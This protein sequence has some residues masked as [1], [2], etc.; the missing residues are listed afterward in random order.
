[1]ET[2]QFVNKASCTK[3]INRLEMFISLDGEMYR[4]NLPIETL[5]TAVRAFERAKK[6]G[7]NYASNIL[8]YPTLSAREQEAL[9]DN[10]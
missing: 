6:E 7:G 2:R 9:L 8:K 1:M 4:G 5:E 10:L 3:A